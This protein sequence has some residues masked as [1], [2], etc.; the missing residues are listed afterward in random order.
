MKY[1]KKKTF[2][3]Y[4]VYYEDNLGKGTMEWFDL[5]GVYDQVQEEEEEEEE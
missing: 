5:G 1:L 2:Y 3:I 4:F